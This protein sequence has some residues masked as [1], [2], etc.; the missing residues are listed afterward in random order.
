MHVT[1]WDVDFEVTMPHPPIMNI[2]ASGWVAGNVRGF[3]S[4]TGKQ[5]DMGFPTCINARGGCTHYK[6]LCD[7][8][9]NS[10]YMTVSMAI[11]NKCIRETSGM[12]FCVQV[13]EMFII[14]CY[15]GVIGDFAWCFC[16]W[17]YWPLISKWVWSGNIIFTNRRQPH[18]TA[19]KSHITI[20]R[21]QEDKL[22]RAISSLFPIHI[23]AKLECTLSNV[24]QNI[25]Q[26]QT[27]TMG[28]TINKKS[29]TT[30]PPP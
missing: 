12:C 14:V 21:H 2:H 28:V 30:E 11:V 22:S 24:Q 6:V 20:T 25:E 9:L 10:T 15:Y 7:F 18:G 23:I 5:H 17:I 13:I 4:K 3:L 16:H 26:L 29:T 8:C 19:R 1:S 27:H